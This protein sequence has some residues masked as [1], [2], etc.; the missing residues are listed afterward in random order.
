MRVTPAEH[1]ELVRG[2]SALVSHDGQG[3]LFV[4]GRLRVD[5][6][7]LHDQWSGERRA[8]IRAATASG[9]DDLLQAVLAG[10]EGGAICL[11]C[12][13]S[14]VCHRCERDGPRDSVYLWTDI[15]ERGIPSTLW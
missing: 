6:D 9:D 8:E 13:V 1:G 15:I 4:A 2:Q 11:E 14:V 12:L 7:D 5:L 10:D 3:W